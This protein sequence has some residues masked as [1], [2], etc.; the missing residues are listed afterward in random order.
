MGVVQRVLDKIAHEHFDACW[1]FC[2][3]FKVIRRDARVCRVFG[4]GCLIEEYLRVVVKT[5]FWRFPSSGRERSGCEVPRESVERGRRWI[6]SQAAASYR[7]SRDERP[8]MA[9]EPCND[10]WLAGEGESGESRCV[11]QSRTGA[12]DCPFGE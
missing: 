8:Q 9:H 10:G 7:Y 2:V 5:I 1:R 6:K 4:I 11:L 12:P 3:P